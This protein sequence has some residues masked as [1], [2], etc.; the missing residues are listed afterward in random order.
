MEDLCFGKKKRENG[1]GGFSKLSKDA[2]K[3]VEAFA[4][5]EKDL[6]FKDFTNE[7]DKIGE[8]EFGKD[9]KHSKHYQ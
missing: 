9:G 8:V 3:A 2:Q 4:K 6:T 1:N 5:T 7:G